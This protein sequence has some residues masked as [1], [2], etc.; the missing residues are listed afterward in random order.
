MKRSTHILLMLAVLIPGAAL[1]L[2]YD[3]PVLLLL[4]TLC[5]LMMVAMMST[6]SDNRKE[7]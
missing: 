7:E 4:P 1:A 5:L 6:M 2:A 3:A